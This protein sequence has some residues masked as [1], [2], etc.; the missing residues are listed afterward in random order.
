M[1]DRYEQINDYIEALLKPQPDK[2]RKLETYADEH[3]VPIMEQAGMEVLLQILSV[4]QAKKILEIGTAIGYSAI[5]MALE[6]PE[7]EIYTIERHEKRHEEALNNVRDF[8]LEDRIHLFYG[9]ALELADEVRPAAPYDVIF[10]DAAKG[11]YKNFFYLYEP[12]LAPD[13]VIITD[14]VLFK[15]LVA[16]DYSKIEPK[17][18]RQL[19][20]KIDHYN[21]WLMDH[22]DYQ[23]AII[24]V[25]DGLA[26]SKKK[27]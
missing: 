19:I 23:T 9:D 13:G 1:N 5:R 20:S 7:A 10:I 14:N 16:E 21:Q 22:P 24:P 18:R 15:G 12:M 6:L 17:R 26:I 11:Q 3:H 27:R 4:K 8:Q 25:G 2:V